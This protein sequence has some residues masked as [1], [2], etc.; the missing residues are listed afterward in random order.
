MNKFLSNI[1]ILVSSLIVSSCENKEQNDIPI[2]WN[3]EKSTQ[4]NKEFSVEEE[5]EINLF[6]QEKLNGK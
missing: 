3:T 6:L 1:L 2:D 4:M 5:L